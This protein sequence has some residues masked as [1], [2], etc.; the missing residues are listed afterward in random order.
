MTEVHQ[1]RIKS[2]SRHDAGNDWD[3][4]E[5]GAGNATVMQQA[6]RAQPSPHLVPPPPRHV[7]STNSQNKPLGH[8]ATG[9]TKANAWPCLPRLDEV[10]VRQ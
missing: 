7:L 4:T 8:L 5:D 3:Q 9:A 6:T 2:A 10:V 1:V